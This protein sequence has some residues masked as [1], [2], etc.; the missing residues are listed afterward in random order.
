MIK[1]NELRIGN[2]IRVYNFSDV[3]PYRNAR[4]A[5]IL[6]DGTFYISDGGNAYW[7][8]KEDEYT[9]IEVIALTPE[10]LEKCGGEKNIFWLGG[11][12]YIRFIV[13]SY[14]LCLENESDL[15]N[16]NSEKQFDLSVN[17]L[18]ELQNL[19]FAL[20]QKELKIEL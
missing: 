13:H 19:Y 5:G 1:A 11:G 12:F 9:R 6:E 7:R 2:W 10:L 15:I 17:Y 14:W 16:A 20:N 3:V 8:L 18:H 4:V